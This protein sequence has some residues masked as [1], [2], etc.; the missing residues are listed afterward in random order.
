MHALAPTLHTA[1]EQ[2]AE[3]I[4]TACHDGTYLRGEEDAVVAG[5][6]RIMDQHA[7]QPCKTLVFC[8]DPDEARNVGAKLGVTAASGGMRYGVAFQR[9]NGA[10]DTLVSGPTP[11]GVAHR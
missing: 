11:R 10:R 2:A 1:Q 8:A 9:R 5:A 6:L 7:C 3:A 4:V